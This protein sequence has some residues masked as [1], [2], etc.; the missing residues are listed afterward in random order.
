[1]NLPLSWLN[2]YMDFNVSAQDYCDGMTMSGSKVEG[3]EEQGAEFT[4][5][6]VGKIVKKEKHPDADSLWVCQVDFGDHISQIITAAQNVF[7]GAVIPVATPG[8]VLSDGT[9]IKKGK[10]R[11]LPSEGMMCSHEE[12]GLLMEDVPGANEDGI[13]IFQEDYPLGKDVREVLGL[14]ETVVEFEI[15]SNRPD[16]LSVL[17]LARES[18][19][20]FGL[21]FRAPVIKETGNSES[22]S[23]YA[24][25]RVEA[26]DL[27]P[28]YI[29]R[30]VKNLKIEPSPKW[31]RER[32]QASGVR[33]I[34]NIVDITNYVMLEYGQPMHAFDLSFLEGQEIIVRRAHD[35][36]E[37]TT[38]DGQ[39]RKL[40]DEMLVICDQ[41]KPVAVAGVMGGENSEITDETRTLLFESAF[42]VRSTVRRTTRKLGMRTEASARYE[43][44]L[45]PQNCLPAV[46][47]ACEL[48]EELGAGEVV[49]GMID[50]DTSDHTPYVLDFRPDKINAFL[51]SE[52]DAEFMVK[53]LTD[54]GFKVDMEQKKIVVPSCRADVEGEADVAEEV[55]RMYGYNRIGS[56]LVSGETTI[57]GKKP[58]MQLEE[59]I[60]ECLIAQGHYEIMTYSFTNPKSLDM[61]N[62]SEEQ[63]QVI[64]IKNPLGEE[65][66][67]MRSNM[68]SSVM[69]VL[70]RNY[71]QRNANVKV[72]EIGKVYIPK[73]LPLTEL[74]DEPKKIALGAYGNADFFTL[75]GA[76]EA[77]F[78]VAG[79][80]NVQYEPLCD[81]KTF[82][83]GKTATVLVHKKPIGV[84]GEIHPEV[85]ARYGI[86]EAVYVAELDFASI[87][88]ASS[89][90]R[91]YKPLGKFPAVT[92][93]IAMLVDD[94]VRVA[95]IEEIIRKFSG[96][97][98]ED[99]I[100]FD[101]YKGK[102]IP[103]GKKSVAYSA[104]YRADNRTL[105]D[106]DINKVFDRIVKNLSEQL[107]AQLR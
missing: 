3:F 16:C 45:D 75:K 88:A 19:V 29:A 93:D 12:L 17:G 6:L 37:I 36:E 20:T 32:L 68:I 42:F 73:A 74:P 22:A 79:I 65:N 33:P 48:I 106:D 4:G 40:D 105:T 26:S 21:P 31:L 102:Q 28:R 44:G 8:A 27:C 18:A 61:I 85:S 100:L 2:D 35:G 83:P 76:L 60:K 41:K 25:V 9:K 1:M 15:T 55:A 53:T 67:I 81:N 51:G 69:E 43:K 99:L 30:V 64:R 98:L 54:L 84:I 89:M 13:L 90:D 103:E 97:L 11:G 7:E 52:I 107:G 77:L 72:F 71:N 94:S 63:R 87:F 78:E 10:L 104:V 80:H 24:R 66:S 47:R 49:G 46:N 86:D 70:A 92:R 23:Q 95:Q 91:T 5:V 62:A 59:R 82:H 50:V 57:G 101:V 96:K 34:N 14:T 39:L 58:A 38:L 56:S